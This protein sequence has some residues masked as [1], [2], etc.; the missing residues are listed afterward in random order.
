MIRRFLHTPST[1]TPTSA[2]AT[3]TTTSTPPPVSAYLHLVLLKRHTPC[4]LQ[5]RKNIIVVANFVIIFVN[6]PTLVFTVAAIAVIVVVAIAA[7][8]GV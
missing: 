6:V 8:L 7:L 2:T 4:K 5:V 3:S 1:T